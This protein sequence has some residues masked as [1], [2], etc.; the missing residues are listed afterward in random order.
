MSAVAVIVGAG[1]GSR[2]GGDKVFAEL[3][4]RPLLVHTGAAFEASPVV[5]G[6][7]LV[8]REENLARG[9]ALA[10]EQGWTKLRAV[11]AGGARR[12]DSVLAGLRAAEADWVVVHDAARPLVTPDLIERG[13]EAA[14]DTGA[15]IAALPVR[16]TIKRVEHDQIVATVDRSRLW[17]AQTPQVF[18]SELLE[19]ALQGGHDVTDDAAAVEALGVP[20]RVYL[21]LERNLKVTTAADLA[22]A[23]AILR[24]G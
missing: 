16:D 17:T 6:I 22:L 7:V 21:G 19:L 20:V 18:R 3:A 10:E 4:G 1:S 2:F 24:C 11:T 14:R 8:L 12:Q 5:D 9:R 15:A 23:E 13:L